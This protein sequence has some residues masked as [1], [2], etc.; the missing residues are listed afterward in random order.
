MWVDECGWTYLRLGHF[1]R[2]ILGS[3]I[4][5]K[6]TEV[7]MVFT[8]ILSCIL[9]KFASLIIVTSSPREE[10]RENGPRSEEERET[11]PHLKVK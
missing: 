3:L 9:A 1:N 11:E 4:Y 10:G 7:H 8:Y 6:A 5:L 2:Q